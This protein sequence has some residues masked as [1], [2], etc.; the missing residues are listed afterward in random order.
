M[1]AATYG[2]DGTETNM[3]FAVPSLTL[4]SE[5][6]FKGTQCT[7]EDIEDK[8]AKQSDKVDLGSDDDYIYVDHS[9]DEITDEE[10]GGYAYEKNIAFIGLHLRDA[11]GIRL[12]DAH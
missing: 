5:K 2:D 3:F 10:K 8:S 1:W 7:D 4:F 6:C 9:N 11:F 12:Q